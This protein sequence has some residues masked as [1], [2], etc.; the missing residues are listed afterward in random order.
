M[1][2]PTP[3]KPTKKQH[4]LYQK[5][6]KNQL[7]HIVEAY[8]NTQEPEQ[9][10]FHN[11]AAPLTLLQPSSPSSPV[12][13]FSTLL[14]P[15]E[16]RFVHGLAST[17]NLFHWSVGE[18]VQRHV[19][20]SHTEPPSNSTAHP[21]TPKPQTTFH[22]F[23]PDTASYYDDPKFTLPH[24]HRAAIEYL[25]QQV[26]VQAS[27]MRNT[28]SST[29][30]TCAIRSSPP[31]ASTPIAMINT[32]ETLQS[33]AHTLSLLPEFA[34]DLE[35]H[36]VHSYNGIT[37]LIQLSTRD[38]DYIVDVLV[39]WD[40][41][42]EHLAP[43]FASP[44]IVKI[45]HA[46]SGGDI[47]ALHRDFNIHCL[48]IFDTQ[49]SARVLFGSQL[50]LEHLLTQYLNVQQLEHSHI[51][52]MKSK[53]T[54]CDWRQRP[55]PE[56]AILY[57]RM[58]THFL[59]E[60]KERLVL[61]MCG[62][63]SATVENDIDTMLAAA[64]AFGKTFNGGTVET[65]STFVPPPY[66]S[67]EEDEEDDAG[68][69]GGRTVTQTALVGS[70]DVQ[71]DELCHCLDL[72]HKCSQA[73]FRAKKKP[74]RLINKDKWYKKAL[75]GWKNKKEAKELLYRRLFAWRDALARKCDESSHFVCPSEVLVNITRRTP[76]SFDALIRAW[77]PL[78]P[79]LR[80]VDIQQ[81]LF[82]VIEEWKTKDAASFKEVDDAS[83][84]SEKSIAEE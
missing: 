51:S 54:T 11:S 24:P 30:S 48:N 41:I 23:R 22:K 2:E 73:L 26:P 61:E 81:T 55:L 14:T 58:D 84:E 64:S 34:V 28:L 10:N 71:E 17:C 78:P 38:K 1:N 63:Q 43:L 39:L 31:I 8:H 65:K 62:V 57:A 82:D 69:E 6:R 52:N 33:M 27:L 7:R 44:S 45:F 36:N 79:L 21:Q 13:S 29:A 5:L 42:H 83:T 72:S 4:K 37:C 53:W 32:V 66:S 47:P 3:S 56:E 59:I 19:C 50:S 16:R 68:N 74:N 75:K 18:G 12:V 35:M 67:D 25:I 46:C 60:L 49:I 40:S 20:I 80:N 9:A 15:Q 70:S 77:S 76:T